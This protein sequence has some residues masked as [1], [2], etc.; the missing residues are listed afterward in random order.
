MFDAFLATRATGWHNNDINILI[1]IFE[2]KIITSAGLDKMHSGT[3]MF[4]TVVL[5]DRCIQILLLISHVI[6]ILKLF[7]FE[8]L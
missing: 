4:F 2:T 3:F 7:K 8:T 6:N 5:V 1:L